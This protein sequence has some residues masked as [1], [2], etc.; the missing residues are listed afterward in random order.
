MLFY[1]TATGNCLYIAKQFDQ[2]PISIPQVIH[3]DHLVFE[4]ET[5]G[6]VAPVYAGELPHLVREF[7]Q[8][9]TFKT[10]YLYLLLTYGMNDSVAGQWS[11][12]M[13]KEAGKEVAFIQTIKMVDNY[14][15]AFDMNEQ[16]AMDKQIP[17]QIALAKQK[18]ADRVHEIPVPTADG[19]EKYAMVKER[20]R[21]HPEFNNGQQIQVTDGCVGCGLCSRVCPIGNFYVAD[22]KAKRK[23]E[24]CEFCLAC[25]HSCPRKAI[26][27]SIAD[28]NPEARYRHPDIS[29]Q[30]IIKA[31]EQKS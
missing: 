17:Q 23:Q 27:M 21:Q 1:F 3:Q 25:A 8:K 26:T 29:L 28:K 15:P 14:L 9:A 16:M 12:N 5:I 22:G 30:E 11:Y 31:N 7:I 20:N 10:D 18:I 2:N 19:Q 4:A 24:T 6:I 13:A